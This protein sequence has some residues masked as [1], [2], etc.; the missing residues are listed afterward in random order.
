M[1]DIRFSILLF[2]A[3]FFFAA[4]VSASMES[5]DQMSEMADKLNDQNAGEA[6]REEGGVSDEEFEMG[7]A[8]PY[9][10]NKLPAF[11]AEMKSVHADERW[12]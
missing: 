7:P 6:Q 8:I 12:S 4:P 5:F 10:P 11:L 9:D 2:S 3:V 1:K